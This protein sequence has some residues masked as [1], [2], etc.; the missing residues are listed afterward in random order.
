[1]DRIGTEAIGSLH[2][3]ALGADHRPC[4]LETWLITLRD[5]SVIGRVV[6]LLGGAPT[7]SHDNGPTPCVITDAR[8]VDILP[9]WSRGARSRLAPPI[10]AC[11]RRLQ[12]A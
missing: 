8:E 7:G 3:G 9:E 4:V 2:Y 10:R 1:M 11:L 5:A 6:D 12:P